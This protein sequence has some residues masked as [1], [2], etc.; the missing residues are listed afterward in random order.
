MIIIKEYS[1]KIV[2]KLQLK[3][4]QNNSAAYQD[5]HSHMIVLC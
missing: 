1:F 3:E 5:L 4:I 2:M